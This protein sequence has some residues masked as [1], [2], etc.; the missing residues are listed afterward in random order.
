MAGYVPLLQYFSRPQPGQNGG[1]VA[2]RWYEFVAACNGA[3]MGGIAAISS[4]TL[5]G[6]TKT[7]GNLRGT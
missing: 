4:S 1:H 3:K 6:S 7:V 5:G 2:Q